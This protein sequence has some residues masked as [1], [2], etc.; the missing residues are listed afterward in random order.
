MTDHP[1]EPI[2]ITD[3]DI[4]PAGGRFEECP[5]SDSTAPGG[6][7]NGFQKC[8]NADLRIGNPFGHTSGKLP[9]ETEAPV[10]D[11]GELYQNGT[12]IAVYPLNEILDIP[13]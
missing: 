10:F 5:T 12:H 1:A 13:G 2:E 11:F 8:R 6:V 7:A 9:G 3:S 4:A